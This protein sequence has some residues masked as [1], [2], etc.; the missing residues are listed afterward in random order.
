MTQ[1]FSTGQASAA[2]TE[3]ALLKGL[4]TPLAAHQVARLRPR[5]RRRGGL[6]GGQEQ[7]QGPVKGLRNRLDLE[8]FTLDMSWDCFF[9]L[10]TKPWRGLKIVKLTKDLHGEKR[11]N[12]QEMD[13]KLL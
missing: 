6:A 8:E 4:V 10:P 9:F 13:L 5:L 2:A 7:F 11:D 12:R 1:S 3:S